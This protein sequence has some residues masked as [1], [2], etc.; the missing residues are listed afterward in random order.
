MK[1][2][3]KCRALKEIRKQIAE[4][5]DIPFAVSECQHQGDCRGTCPKCESELLYLEREL[6]IRKN[7][8]RAVAVVGISVGACG[9]L[10]SC[11]PSDI[12]ENIKNIG[13]DELA[14]DVSPVD[15]EGLMVEPDFESKSTDNFLNGE[16][17]EYIPE[18]STELDGDIV[19]TEEIK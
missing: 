18:E 1:G 12:I 15:I 6:A 16:L 9:V 11:S 2:K 13:Y 19:I 5:N 3:E 14:G 17:E 7:L 10:T 4:N 8:G